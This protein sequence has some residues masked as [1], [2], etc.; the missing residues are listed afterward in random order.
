MRLAK[1]FGNDALQRLYRKNCAHFVP[2]I[3]SCIFNLS[4]AENGFRTL[5]GTLGLRPNFHQKEKRVDGHVFIT[6]LAYQLLRHILAK[7][8]HEGDNRSWETIRRILK[9]HAYTTMIIPEVDGDIHRI[10]KAGNPDE[11][12]KA[13]YNVLGVNWNKLPTWHV[14]ITP[15]KK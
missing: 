11:S 10:R 15:A 12:Q 5:K 3:A 4:T 8:D 9:T 1:S 14:H 6:I 7:L 13:I 2:R